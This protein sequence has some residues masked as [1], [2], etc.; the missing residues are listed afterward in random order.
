VFW[1]FVSSDAS[2]RVDTVHFFF[3]LNMRG[4]TMKID[5]EQ[6][7]LTYHARK[8]K[9]NDIQS[10][11]HLYQGNPLYFQYCP[12]EVSEEMVRDDMH[13]LPKGKTEKDK[14]FVGYYEQNKLIAVMDLIA[15]YPG[16]GTAFIGFFMLA[17]DRQG[18]GTGSA[19]VN[20]LCTY[21]K[22]SGAV[23]I[24]LAWV[25]RNPQAEHF[26][27]KNGFVKVKE[28]ASN[29]ADCVILAEKNLRGDELL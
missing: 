17:E 13:A 4:N 24:Q 9:E 11:Y 1:Y 10:I 7:S 8:L 18:N 25:K 23:R 3:T 2:G 5:I 28:T 12:P 6:L 20:E 21:L 19:L 22:K 14:Y 15:D 26:W 27:L 16:M 29:A